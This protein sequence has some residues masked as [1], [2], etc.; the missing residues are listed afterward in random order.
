[1]KNLNDVREGVWILAI[2]AFFTAIILLASSIQ[3]FSFSD[4]YRGSPGFPLADPA[5]PSVT[6]A[7]ITSGKFLFMAF[8]FLLLSVFSYFVGKGLLGA[9]KWSKI[10]VGAVSGVILLF[11]GVLFYSS[12]FA[13]G[14]IGLAIA[15][16]QI[17]YLFFNKSIKKYFKK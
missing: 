14:T 13:L 7:H 17:W 10:A 8:P 4:I 15:G 9:K 3:L 5:N 6:V 12:F 2:L 11:S 16:L 1:M